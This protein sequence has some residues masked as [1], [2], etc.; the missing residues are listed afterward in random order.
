MDMIIS[1]NCFQGLLKIFAIV[2]LLLLFCLFLVPT[3]ARR[4]LIAS[5]IFSIPALLII[6]L[7]GVTNGKTKPPLGDVGLGLLICSALWVCFTCFLS[8]LCGIFCLRKYPSVVIWLIAEVFIILGLGLF[9]V[10]AFS[11]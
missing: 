5:F 4:L 9:V 2:P 3:T 6:G 10:L 1:E 7:W 11:G 8:V